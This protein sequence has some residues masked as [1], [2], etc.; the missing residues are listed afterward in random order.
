MLEVPYTLRIRGMW[1]NGLALAVLLFAGTVNAYDVD[2]TPESSAWTDEYPG[3]DHY[4][5][6][7]YGALGYLDPGYAFSLATEYGSPAYDTSGYG[8]HGYGGDYGGYP[9]YGPSGYGYPV[10][11]NGR[12]VRGNYASPY[13]E[14]GSIPAANLEYIRQL[15]ERVRKLEKAN[16]QT[17]EQTLPP[18]NGKYSQPAFSPYPGNQSAYE[19]PGA[20]YP[21]LP[22]HR[23]SGTRA[24]GNGEYPTYQPRYG[25]PPTYQ[26]RQ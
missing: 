18:Y 21:G 6:P 8:A 26:F 14:S 2:N 13:G 11:G 7:G 25:G 20:G 10:P 17:N 23:S 12:G 4:D 19:A 24:G 5:Y 3:G 1:R 16:Q 9:A 22:A 15:E